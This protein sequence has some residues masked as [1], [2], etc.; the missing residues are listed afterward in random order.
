MQQDIH[1]FSRVTNQYQDR[2]HTMVELEKSLFYP[3]SEGGQLG[4]RGRIGASDVVRVYRAENGS[5]VHEILTPIGQNLFE[6]VECVIS[7][8]RRY[9]IAQQ[10]TAQHLFSADVFN[11]YGY[12]TVGF[13]MGEEYTTV[14]IDTTDWDWEKA[15]IIEQMILDQILSSLEIET[16][17]VPKSDI[18]LYPLRKKMSEKIKDL[19]VFRLIKIGNIDYSLCGGF[20]LNRTSELGIFK[21]IKYERIKTEWHRIYFL[22]G[23]R[24]LKDY[25]KK[26]LLLQETTHS[27]STSIDELNYRI[28]N[29]IEE[30][31]EAKKVNRK[32]SE[33]LASA[34]YNTLR[35]RKPSEGIQAVVEIMPSEEAAKGLSGKLLDEKDTVAFLLY[36]RPKGNGYILSSTREELNA[37]VVFQKVKEFLE[38]KGGGTEKMVQGTVEGNISAIKEQCEKVIKEYFSSRGLL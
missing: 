36:E 20:H 38:I 26:T 17:E 7:G 32:L 8:E 3:D 6:S 34:L 22:A 19:E 23:S 18:H 33:N 25:Q 4:D 11:L 21:V 10:H 14:D 37:R 1:F 13:S 30:Q 12:E 9:D 16:L 28:H 24:A 5:I 31:Q 15:H 35:L 2:D 27:L 29:I